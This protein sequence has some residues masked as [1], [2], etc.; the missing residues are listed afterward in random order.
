MKT[1][2]LGSTLWVLI[3]HIIHT[4]K[5]GKRL[6]AFLKGRV[7]RVDVRSSKGEGPEGV[8]D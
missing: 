7:L 1:Y 4:I 8:K 6:T 2:N 3:L 5:S